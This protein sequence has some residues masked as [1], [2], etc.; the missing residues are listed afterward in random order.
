[1]SEVRIYSFDEFAGGATPRSM[2]FPGAKANRRRVTGGVPGRWV[3]AV[4]LRLQNRAAGMIA[5]GLRLSAR[6]FIKNVRVIKR[7]A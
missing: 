2:D 7:R 4:D 5:L 1:M 6:G 3:S